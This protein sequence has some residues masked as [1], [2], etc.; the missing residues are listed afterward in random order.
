VMELT[1]SEHQLGTVDSSSK[2]APRQ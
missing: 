2:S 1:L